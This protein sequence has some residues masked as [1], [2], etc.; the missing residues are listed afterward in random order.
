MAQRFSPLYLSILTLTAGGLLITLPTAQAAKPTKPPIAKSSKKPIAKKV[1]KDAEGSTNAF[2]AVVDTPLTPPSEMDVFLQC[3]QISDNAARLA[4]FDKVTTLTTD[5][6]T[7]FT[8]TKQPLDIAK[9]VGTSLQQGKPTAV[10]AGT[11]SNSASSNDMTSQ[12][13]QK[14]SKVTKDEQILAQVGVEKQ[15]LQQYTPLSM[16]YDLGK[17]DPKGV[18]SIRPHQP[19]YVLPI[20][21]NAQPNRRI[22]SPTHNSEKN[23]VVE[24]RSSEM[25]N[26]DSKMQISLKT[27]VFEDVFKTNADVWVGYTQQSYW[28]V[29]NRHSRPF[30]SSDYQPEIFITQPV[31]AQLPLSGDL[32][33]VGAG[34]VHQSNGQG[35]PLSRSWNRAY[36]MGGA[37][38][39]N[40]MVVP[41]LWFIFPEN[42]HTSDNPDISD[43]MGYG[44]VR[45][46]YNLGDKNTVGGLVRYNPAENKG[47]I[48]LDY[49][50][51]ITGGMKGYIQVFHGYG[52]NIQDYNHKNTTLGLGVMFNDFL[53]L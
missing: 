36:L 20:F 24:Y 49:A 9:T 45:F 15:D 43:Y 46:L 7:T 33:V 22:E 8:A 3:K 25:M 37:E 5:T 26:L 35:D 28:Q 34:L 11:P 51:P 39:G 27:K 41:R 21:Y 17:N 12:G 18:L 48:Q 19:M 38:W 50:R 32:R 40:L 13:Y 42:K 31:K 47:A 52:E 53:G 16:L 29:Y 2:S 6:A 10:L 4:C 23:G 44:D 1:T 14:N 30:R